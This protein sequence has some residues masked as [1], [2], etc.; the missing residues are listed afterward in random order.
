M[1]PGTAQITATGH[2]VSRSCTI[3]VCYP[4]SAVSF[5]Q[6]AYTLY[7]DDR[8]QLTANVTT[9]DGEFVNQLIAFTTSDTAVAT[10][11]AEGLVTVHSPGSATIT[12][13]AASGVSAVCTITAKGY[14]TLTLP[15]E[16]TAISDESLMNT[17]AE[18]VLIPAGCTAIGEKAFAGS[19][20]LLAVYMPDS[21][22]D[23]AANAFDGCESIKFIC[24]SD[25]AAARYAREHGIPCVIR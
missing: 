24:D 4:V 8:Q 19:P 15:A 12:A 2:G 1:K 13:T 20:R 18:A 3:R 6:S 9:R 17:G 11:S 21:I 7:V 10:V 22:A 5:T 14:L 25:N 16:L 23:I